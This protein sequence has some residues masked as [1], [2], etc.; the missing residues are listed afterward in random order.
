MDVLVSVCTSEFPRLDA[1]MFISE[2]C[3]PPVTSDSLQ[4][5]LITTV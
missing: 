5:E 2:H 3:V 1:F 4:L